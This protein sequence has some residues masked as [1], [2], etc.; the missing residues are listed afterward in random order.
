MQWEL[1][2]LR[3]NWVLSGRIRYRQDPQASAPERKTAVADNDLWYVW[4]G[5]GRLRTRQGWIEFVPGVCVWARPGWTY[6]TT[7][8]DAEP[9]GLTYL[10]FDFL[11]AAGQPLR[12]PAAA[13]P[14]ELLTVEDPAFTEAVTRHVADFCQ[15]LQVGTPTA[16]T[17]LPAVT[18]LFR[19]L[20][21]VLAASSTASGGGEPQPPG[22]AVVQEMLRRLRAAPH[23]PPAVADLAR[24]S[25]YTR[26][27]LNR[28]FHGATGMSTKQYLVASRIARARQLLADPRLTIAQVAAECGYDDPFHFSRQFRQV[29][30]QSPSACRARGGEAVEGI[31]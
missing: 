20:L 10:H 14:P 4:A 19:G 15:A 27:H 3:L 24:E 25:G 16:A 7:Q 2:D 17:R 8:D 31:E 1:A 28:L 6:E 22:Q 12:L 23:A 5:R 21:L 30:G 11:N 18:A 13:L 26:Q 29:T 9:L